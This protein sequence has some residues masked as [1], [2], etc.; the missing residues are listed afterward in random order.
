MEMLPT[1][2]AMGLSTIPSC[3]NWDATMVAKH[4]QWR[5]GSNSFSELTSQSIFACFATTA[6]PAEQGR[7][8]SRRHHEIQF[9]TGG[10][11]A[12]PV[13]AGIQFADTQ[14]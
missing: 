8:C 3:W 6:A 2:E 14:A 13:N 10:V 12:C 7:P 5:T 11:N 4:C 9:G 1:L